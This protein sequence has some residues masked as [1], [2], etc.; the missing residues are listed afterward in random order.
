MKR[1]FTLVCAIACLSYGVAAFSQN[2]T[3]PYLP[4]FAA[5]RPKLASMSAAD[6]VNALRNYRASHE[7][8]V[9]CEGFEVDQLQSERERQLITLL[10]GKEKLAAQAVYHCAA[11]DPKTTQ[12]NGSV[13]DGTAHPFSAGLV[14]LALPQSGEFTLVARIAESTAVG[15]YTAPLSN[16][17]DGKSATKIVS[18]SGKISVTKLKRGSALIAIFSGRKPHSFTKAVWYF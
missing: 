13:E 17:L 12:C 16:L 10:S 9:A 7:N 18:T 4:D 6:A 15:V 1:L 14:P 11:F 8:P 5:L 2:D 3:C